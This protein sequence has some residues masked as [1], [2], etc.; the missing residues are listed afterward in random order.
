MGEKKRLLDGIKVVDLTR[1]Y[2]G[3]FC[4][5]ILADMGADIVK[6]EDVGPNSNERSWPPFADGTQESTYF[7]GLNRGKKS[8]ELNLKEARARE[9]F[10]KLAK[11]ADFVIEN[12]A[13][14]V[15]Q[16]LLVDYENCR[17]IKSDII[18][19]PF[20]HLVNMDR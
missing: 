20:R 3:P 13:T 18:T 4:S 11:D 1:V 15:A 5:Q 19:F 9:I 14:G 2:T 6:I 12:Y 7:I 8:I 16:K 17:K 10:Y